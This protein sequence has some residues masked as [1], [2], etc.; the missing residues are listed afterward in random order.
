[1]SSVASSVRSPLRL[2]LVFAAFTALSA[3]GDDAASPE[4]SAS[5]GAAGSGGAGAGAGADAGGAG[6]AGPAGAAAVPSSTQLTI[7][8][9]GKDY[10]LDR[11]QFGLTK[12]PSGF[13]VYVEAHFGGD[14]ACPSEASPSP[15][16]TLILTGF[17]ADSAPG[18][19]FDDAS[20]AR[21]TLLD[22]EGLVT[23]EPVL[24]STGVAITTF[25]DNACTSCP[26]EDESSDRFLALTVAATFSDGS[27]LQG[28]IRADHCGSLDQ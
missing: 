21:I 27:Q 7:S 17:P 28:T 12:L 9:G 14:P 19:V 16:R 3:C 1:M 10:P 4:P 13:E 20:G 26:S 18:T 6:E 11:A 15:S 2:L 25:A 24:K 5:A 22:F 8:Q 23:Q